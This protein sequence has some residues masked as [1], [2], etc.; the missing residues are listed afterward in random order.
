LNGRLFLRAG[1]RAGRTVLLESL[2]T[3]PLQVMRPHAAQSPAGG[4]SVVV[5]LSGGL[6]D[7]DEAAID[8]VVE[9]GARLALRTQAATQVHAG[10]SRQTLHGTVG[11]DAWL[12]YLP[13]AVVPHASANYS[14]ETDIHLEADARL[15]LA[16]SLAPGRVRSGEQLAFCQVQLNVDVRSGG[17]ELLARERSLIKPD[18]AVQA[19]QFGP[20]LHTASVY[21][22]GPGEP[23][24]DD[25]YGDARIGR[26]ALARGGWYVRAV[27]NRAASIDAVL[28]RLHADWS[29]FVRP[30]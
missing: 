17:G 26:T 21:L 28:Q 11:A 27:A 15:L 10:R 2:A 4:L 19:A 29:A 7:G 18:P 12:S 23:A 14:S 8:V 20:A 25:C 13:Q 30:A 5:L 22:L 9:P 1:V 16:E 24:I 6:L 3:F